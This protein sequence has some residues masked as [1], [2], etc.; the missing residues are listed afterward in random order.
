MMKSE[1]RYDMN[2][3]GLLCDEP[4][5]DL[6][7]FSFVTSYIACATL[8]GLRCQLHCMRYVAWATL[9]AT[10]HGLR[11]DMLRDTGYVAWATLSATLHG[12]RCMGYVVTC[13]VIRATLHGL[14]WQLHCMGCVAWA[15]LA[16]TL[17]RLRCMGYVGSYIAWATWIRKN[18][19]QS[20]REKALNKEPLIRSP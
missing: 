15:T 4:W 17:H 9:S 11:C 10:L 14:R 3:S 1:P 19:S 5:F 2:Q 12:L 8:H 16:A 7:H 20:F 18:P 13:Y 6:R